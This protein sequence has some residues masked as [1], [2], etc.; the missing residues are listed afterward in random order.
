MSGARAPRYATYWVPAPGHPLWTAGCTWLGRDP[1][2][3]GAPGSP[4]RG[5][6]AAPWRYG[7]HATL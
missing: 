5:H 3:G 1:R 2:D 4:A 6:V 7:V